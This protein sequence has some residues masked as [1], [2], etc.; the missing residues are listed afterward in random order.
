MKRSLLIAALTAL[1][2]AL[3]A[4]PLAAEPMVPI[5]G[6][7]LPDADVLPPAIPITSYEACI[8][9]ALDPTT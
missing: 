8:A 1:L 6:E 3:F 5:E 9:E 2:L 4:L 7:A